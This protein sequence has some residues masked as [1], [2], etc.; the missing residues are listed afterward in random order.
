ML[1]G[2]DIENQVLY[3]GDMGGGGKR[4]LGLRS[5]APAVVV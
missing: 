3:L 1:G 2:G 4:E 5:S